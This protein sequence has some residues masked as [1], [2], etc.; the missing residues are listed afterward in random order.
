MARGVFITFEGGE[1]SGKSTH[2]ALLEK[3][4]SAS[5]YSVVRTREPGGTAAAEKIRN[6][7]VGGDPGAWSPLAEALLMNAARDAHLREIIRPAL[8][9]GS[10][11]L[12]DRFMDSTRAYQGSA[13]G[14]APEIIEVLERQVVGDTVPDVTVILDL[15]A[16][17]G[18]ERSRGR[19][20]EH[21]RFERKGLAFHQR[22]RERFLAIARAEPHR[23]TVIDSAADQPAV[24]NAI[25][26]AVGRV[27]RHR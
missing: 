21:E 7:L 18:L 27:L 1:G 11:V 3:K 6:L 19:G 14:V 17:A 8:A 9:S 20:G 22:V 25:W 15:D 23:C 10:I 4:L 24:A 16:A 2:L 12:S 13:G 5:G 26:E